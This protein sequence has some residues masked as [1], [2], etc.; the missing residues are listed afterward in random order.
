MRGGEVY[1]EEEEGM[2]GMMVSS[3]WQRR[4]IGESPSS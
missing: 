1:P 3:L 2:E 4:E